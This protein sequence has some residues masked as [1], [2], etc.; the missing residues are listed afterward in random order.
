MK[1]KRW[2]DHLNSICDFN[3]VKT[4]FL[5]QNGRMDTYLVLN[6]LFVD[7][8]QLWIKFIL[9]NLILSYLTYAAVQSSESWV[10]AAAPSVG[11]IDTTG[12]VK[13]RIA[14]TFINI[15]KNG[16]HYPRW[17]QAL[18]GWPST[19]PGTCTRLCVFTLQGCVQ[20]ARLWRGSPVYG[21]FY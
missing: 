13:T 7:C 8:T 20:A 21:P 19:Q 14:V 11:H 17:H 10:A 12:T 4:A 18:H 16:G 15:W 6:A 5:Y 9:A 3:P 1:I 2:W